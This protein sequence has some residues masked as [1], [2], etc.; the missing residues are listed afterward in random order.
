[1]TY[2]EKERFAIE[3]ELQESSCDAW[4]FGRFCYWIANTQIGNF[5][6]GTSLRDILFSMSY[7]RGDAGKRTAPLLANYEKK[8]IFRLIHKSINEMGSDLTKLI[9]AELMPASFDVCPHVDIFNDW[10]IFLVDTKENSTIFYSLDGGNDVKQFKL[11]LG[12]FDVV[13]ASACRE[14]DRLLDSYGNPH[15]E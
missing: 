10:H 8:E 12:E 3:F 9:P 5:D 4:M 15:T 2:G 13:V 1:M 6:E 14:M 11:S 7:I